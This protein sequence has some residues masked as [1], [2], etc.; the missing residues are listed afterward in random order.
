MCGQGI[1]VGRIGM[2]GIIYN[3]LVRSRYLHIVG[4]LQLTVL[5]LILFQTHKGRIRIGLA[6]TITI[7]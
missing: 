1:G 4:R 6:V 7:A 2:Q 3:E 5:H